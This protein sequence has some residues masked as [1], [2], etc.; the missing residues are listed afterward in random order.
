MQAGRVWS[1]KLHATLSQLGFQQLK[2]DASLYIYSRDSLHIMVPVFIDN[3]TIA[4]PSSAASDRF[5]QELAQHFELRDLGPTSWLLGIQ[6]TRDR[7][8]RTLSLSQRQIPSR[9]KMVG[10]QQM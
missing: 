9:L 6:I 10:D 1:K 3:I 2:S 8:K 4:S 7:S 5:V